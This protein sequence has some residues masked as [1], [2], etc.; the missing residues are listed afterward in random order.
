MQNQDI[1]SSYR[2]IAIWLMVGI[3]MLIIQVLLGGITRLTGSGLSITEWKPIIGMLP[4]VNE[5][6]WNLAFEKYKQIAQFKLLNPHFTLADF[7]H[8]YFWEWFHR[9][10]A[11]LIAVAFLV[12]FVIFIIRK[13]FQKNMIRP[14]VI[15]FLLGAMQGLAGWL[16]VKSGLEDPNRVYVT[17][18]TL[19]IHFVLAM[20]LIGYTLWFALKLLIPPKHFIISP[21]GTNFTIILF[22]VLAV[23]LVYGSFMAG[24]KAA[25][26]A[27]TWPGINGEFFPHT[28]FSIGDRNYPGLSF[29]TDNPLVVHFIHRMLAYLIVGLIICWRLS[30]RRTMQTQFQK[31]TANLPILLVILQVLLG[32]FSLFNVS[33][34]KNFIW[35]AEAHQLTAMLLFLSLLVNLYIL[36]RNI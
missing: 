35:I 1:K 28:V 10:W 12:P 14:M 17:H 7:K 16:M 3:A 15:L 23:Q 25:A 11:R 27:P 31:S 9:L 20:L 13:K 8:I 5:S 4:P 18:Y 29:L 33:T 36:R 30:I 26:M 21:S 34:P 6:D 22:F 24:L 19:A 2:P 32:I